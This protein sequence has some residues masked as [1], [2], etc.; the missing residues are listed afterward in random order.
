MNVCVCVCAN[1][2]WDFSSL[3]VEAIV[4]TENMAWLL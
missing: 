1:S 3:Y 4:P 2:I